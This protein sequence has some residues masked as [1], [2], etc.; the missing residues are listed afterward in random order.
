ME[1]WHSY[2]LGQ[3]WNVKGTRVCDGREC[4]LGTNPSLSVLVS[5]A[6]SHNGE[7]L[8]VCKKRGICSFLISL[9][10]VTLQTVPQ[11]SFQREKRSCCEGLFF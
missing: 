9:L 5:N 6:Q 2:V 10:Y 4:S 11:L 1:R 3:V 8:C 7:I